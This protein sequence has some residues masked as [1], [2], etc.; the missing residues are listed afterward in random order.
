MLHIDKKRERTKSYVTNRPLCVVVIDFTT[1]RDVLHVSIID[2]GSP[3]RRLTIANP[4]V[5]CWSNLSITIAR[6][7]QHNEFAVQLENH[8]LVMSNLPSLSR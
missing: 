5:A 7:V 1:M 3:L 4:P 6:F 8:S 2:T